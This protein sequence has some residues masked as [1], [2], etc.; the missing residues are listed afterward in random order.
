M[1]IIID[2]ILFVPTTSYWAT[3]TIDHNPLKG[4]FKW[5]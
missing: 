5:C 2:D 1:E 4:N 3:F